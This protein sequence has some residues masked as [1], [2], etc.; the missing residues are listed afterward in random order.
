MLGRIAA[1]FGG[2]RRGARAGAIGPRAPVRAPVRTTQQ[3]K[4]LETPEFGER[5][6]R[7]PWL[8][9]AEGTCQCG[10]SRMVC[11]SS[12]QLT[13]GR[14]STVARMLTI[15]PA[16]GA[17]GKERDRYGSGLAGRPCAV[18]YRYPR[19]AEVGLVRSFSEAK[20]SDGGFAEDSE[21]ESRALEKQTLPALD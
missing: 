10:R 7:R 15:C 6:P 2:L 4:D 11:P 8:I 16:T 12:A 5:E 18:V 17:V 9:P 21:T 19:R 14:H 20:R 13:C 1:P 3:R